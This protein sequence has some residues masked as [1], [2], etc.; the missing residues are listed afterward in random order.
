MELCPYDKC[1]HYMAGFFL[2]LIG[3]HF[4]RDELAFAFVLIFAIGKE[5][6][7]HIKYKGYDVTDIIFTM[8][9]IF[10]MIIEK[11]I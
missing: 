10:I 7:D 11:N 8:I 6:R 9:P 1:L 2:A 3:I 4:L 5:I